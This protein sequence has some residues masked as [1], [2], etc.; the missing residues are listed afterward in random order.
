MSEAL[1][2][3]KIG[4]T[5]IRIPKSLPPERG[6]PSW[7]LI[8][9]GIIGAALFGGG[10][11]LASSSSSPKIAEVEKQKAEEILIPTIELLGPDDPVEYEAEE[12]RSLL[13]QNKMLVPFSL[14]LDEVSVEFRGKDWIQMGTKERTERRSITDLIPFPPWAEEIWFYGPKGTKIKFRPRDQKIAD[15][16]PLSQK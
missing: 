3:F 8:I 14:N 4:E 16:K 11:Y 13:E 6:M 12:I 10:M 15:F 1:E 9:I 7:V 5:T 2:D